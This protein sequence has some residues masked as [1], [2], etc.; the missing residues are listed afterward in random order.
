[1]VTVTLTGQP[2]LGVS[3]ETKRPQ[4]MR[5]NIVTD[6][7]VGHYQLQISF[8]SPA[9]QAE[10]ILTIEGSI[11]VDL[12]GGPAVVESVGLAL[13]GSSLPT[14]RVPGEVIRPW[15]SP[16]R[17]YLGSVAIAGWP[18]TPAQVVGGQGMLGIGPGA[19]PPKTAT[20][21]VPTAGAGLGGD[22]IVRG[23]S[24]FSRASPSLPAGRSEI[25]FRGYFSAD[26]VDGY[27]GL[28][29]QPMVTFANAKPGIRPPYGSVVSSGSRTTVYTKMAF[30][31]GEV[32]LPAQAGGPEIA[33]RVPVD[34]G[35]GTAYFPS[36]GLYQ[37]MDINSNPYAF[38]NFTGLP[39]T[40]AGV[41]VITEPYPLSDLTAERRL[42]V[43]VSVSQAAS[44]ITIPRHYYYQD[45][46][47]LT[48]IELA[49]G[50][51][52][53]VI[54]GVDGGR[55]ARF[56]DFGALAKL[57]RFRPVRS[58]N[59]TY[60]EVLFEDLTNPQEVPGA[61]WATELMTLNLNLVRQSR[62]LQIV[63]HRLGDYVYAGRVIYEWANS[64]N[65][66]FGTGEGEYVPYEILKS[67]NE[68]FIGGHAS[69]WALENL[70]LPG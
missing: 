21:F 53:P 52:P 46:E 36:G 20:F 61:V 65:R 8:V 24:L 15:N 22:V 37:I 3:R 35:Y 45:P 70:S 41:S 17:T 63:D 2:I 47:V 66:W 34:S 18:N 40:T 27:Q 62:L 5:A 60:G 6:Q 43:D 69:R 59:D 30:G 54:G 13:Y 48:S 49:L 50:A 51:D 33:L 1:M 9:S 11:E 68:S 42:V 64:A 4:T 55:G 10:D 39:E 25:R 26:S 14:A 57:M 38:L 28:V 31:L 56:T 58:P 44:T 67:I 7:Q 32:G 12:T 19:V 23:M 29:I 16:K